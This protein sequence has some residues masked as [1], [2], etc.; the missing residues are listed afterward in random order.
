MSDTTE[1]ISQAQSQATQAETEAANAT[2]APS[3]ALEAGLNQV[4]AR[5]GQIEG[6]LSAPLLPVVET[7]V[8]AAD[9]EAGTMVAK[10]VTAAS[11]VAG[12]LDDLLKSLHAH[13]GSKLANQI[14]VPVPG[15]ATTTVVNA[16]NG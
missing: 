1:V 7:L 6:V 11:G 2:P 4:T 5:V 12:V 16:T 8:S 3:N 15:T 9:P 14:G 10:G 13:F